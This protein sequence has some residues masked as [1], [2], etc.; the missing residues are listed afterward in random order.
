L[1][2]TRNPEI[3]LGLKIPGLFL[4]FSTIPWVI[5][6]NPW[7]SHKILGNI[8]GIVKHRIFHG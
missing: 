6:I 1:D 5:P 3:I 4:G 8:P 7:I 2:N